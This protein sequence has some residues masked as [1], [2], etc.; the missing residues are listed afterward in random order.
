MKIIEQSARIL[1]PTS[2][3]AAMEGQKWVEYAGRNCYRSH[4]KTTEDSYEKFIHSLIKRGHGSPLE[5][6]DVT[7]E[8]VTSRD[9]MAEITRHR[10]ASFAIQSQRYVLDDKAGD[11]SFIKPDYYIPEHTLDV[12]AKR[13]CASVGWKL[14]MERA[15]NE[16]KYQVHECGMGPEDARKVLPNSTATVIVMKASL[17]EWLHIF[18]LRW[19][20]A[21][22]P[23]MRT[24]MGKLIVQFRE[25]Y[26]G[27]FDHLEGPHESIPQ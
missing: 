18:D 21:A 20:D 12:D 1:R 26:P 23:E 24:L 6:E 14:S 9:V 13:W 10:F 17:R 27:I 22:Y 8:L 3:A 4:D 16:Y 25:Y 5:F 15:E 7:V 11:I 2:P 19:S